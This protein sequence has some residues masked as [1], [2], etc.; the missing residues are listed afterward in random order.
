M[1]RCAPPSAIAVG[2]WAEIAAA[3]RDECRM[4]RVELLRVEL[5]RVELLCAAWHIR[6]VISSPLILSFDLNDAVSEPEGLRSRGAR[7]GA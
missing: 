3:R 5:V 2:V 7:L 6:C 4:L 1:V